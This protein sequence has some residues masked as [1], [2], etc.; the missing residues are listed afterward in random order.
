MSKT[1]Y[2]HLIAT[3]SETLNL[4]KPI[5]AIYGPFDGEDSDYAGLILHAKHLHEEF[6]KKQED[7]SKDVSN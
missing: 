1:M 3:D 5:T 7:E 4:D 6:K 2:L